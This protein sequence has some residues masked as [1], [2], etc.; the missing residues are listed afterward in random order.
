MTNHADV[1]VRN[2]TVFKF[3]G[4]GYWSNRNMFTYFDQETL[5]WEFYPISP[6]VVPPSMYRFGSSFTDDNYYVYGGL[7]IDPFTGF[8]SINNSNIWVFNFPSRSWDN[9]GVSNIPRFNSEDFIS[10]R[11][12][13]KLILN[14]KTQKKYVISFKE[15]Q[16]NTVESTKHNF[17]LT[18][19]KV[20]FIG[21]S[22]FNINH[23]DKLI[24]SDLKSA[25]D[26]T[27]PVKKTPI[28]V[29]T[30]VL[31]SGLQRAAVLAISL[32]V[33]LIL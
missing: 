16:V 10:L 3:G 14:S 13:K 22:V 33:F 11:P 20:F 30:S 28:Y 18:G 25:L 23:N 2:D 24:Y 6:P 26:Y 9:L 7:L 31:Y 15:N 17:E 19:E 32:L 21:D 27:N 29:N 12:D 8:S 4:Y 1:F 5:E